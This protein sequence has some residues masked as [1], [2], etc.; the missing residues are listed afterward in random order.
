MVEGLYLEFISSTDLL[1][2]IKK[3]QQ[4]QRVVFWKLQSMELAINVNLKLSGR[5][6]KHSLLGLALWISV[7]IT[8]TASVPELYL[9][10]A[11]Q[12]NYYKLATL[13]SSS[14][15]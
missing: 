11:D 12:E 7:L 2:S 10:L 5:F 8:Q 1:Q 3:Q 15:C 14:K 13:P 9:Y 4:R 6:H